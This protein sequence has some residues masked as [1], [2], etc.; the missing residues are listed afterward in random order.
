MEFLYISLS[1]LLLVVLLTTLIISIQHITFA[2]IFDKS[3][4]DEKETEK[5]HTK[6]TEENKEQ[7]TTDSSE[8]ER[9]DAIRD[10]L[11]SGKDVDTI[12][13][14][15]QQKSEQTNKKCCFVP[16]FHC[17]GN[18]C[19]SG[20]EKRCN[21]VANKPCEESMLKCK[22]FGKDQCTKH[23]NSEFC[24]YD[25]I[26]KE[27]KNRTDTPNGYEIDCAKFAEFKSRNFPNIEYDCNN[28]MLFI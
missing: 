12:L 7:E 3:E 16:K 15:L 21:N 25:T 8:Q 18:E 10:M 4:P 23:P 22:L 19:E 11:E 24:R 6:I 9:R 17:S 2:S 27:C 5:K 26:D 28:Q 1:M 20:V 13:Y 14:E